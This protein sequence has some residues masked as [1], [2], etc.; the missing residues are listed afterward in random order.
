MSE[1]CYSQPD[2]TPTRQGDKI[3]KQPQR[4]W[5]RAGRYL[6]RR[7]GILFLFGLA[8]ISIGAGFATIQV[9]RFSKPGPGGPLEFMDTT[10]W[11]GV[12][13]VVC[14]VA[15]VANGLLRRKLHN[16]DAVGYSALIMPPLLWA[17][18]YTIS[19]A[20]YLISHGTAGRQASIIGVFLFLIMVCAILV[21]SHWRDDLDEKYLLLM[22]IKDPAVAKRL[23]E[24]SKLLGQK[25]AGSE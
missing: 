23:L 12:F 13:W 7:G 22:S 8:W 3:V 17:F 18:C 9:D 19:F 11:P 16:E 4:P 14:G 25:R 21:I 5:N 1:A 2:K 24:E 15:A 20:V 10:P 6:G